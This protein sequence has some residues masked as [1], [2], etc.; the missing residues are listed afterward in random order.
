M[1]VMAGLAQFWGQ[2][3]LPL[4]VI[5]QSERIPHD[6]LEQLMIPLR[7][8][9]LVKSQRGAKGGYLLSREPRKITLKEIIQALEGEMA[10][11]VCVSKEGKIIC[12]SEDFCRSKK[13]WKKV[14]D[15]ILY[16]LNSIN[17]KEVLE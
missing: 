1:Q 17:L 10:P 13:V 16:A 7:H 6:Y 12:P 11:V 3:P 4:S 14:Q 5:A 2:G 9:G 8:R 15:G